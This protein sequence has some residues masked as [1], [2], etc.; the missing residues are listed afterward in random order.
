MVNVRWERKRRGEEMKAR[1]RA[2]TAPAP[3]FR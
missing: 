2:A 3:P 1:K